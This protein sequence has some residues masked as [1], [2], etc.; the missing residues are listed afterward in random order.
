[1]FVCVF[2]QGREKEVVKDRN[3]F[4][5]FFI[6]F[7]LTPQVLVLLQNLKFQGQHCSVGKGRIQGG[8]QRLME[9]KQTLTS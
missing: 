5:L 6:L 7:I 8:S 2:R 1:M 4:Y 3:W 9:E